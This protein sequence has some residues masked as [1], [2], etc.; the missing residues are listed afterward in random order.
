[1]LQFKDAFNHPVKHDVEIVVDNA[2]T[3]TAQVVNIHNFC[4]RSG[5]HCSVDSISFID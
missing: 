5:G 2:T 4:L 1:M 3:H